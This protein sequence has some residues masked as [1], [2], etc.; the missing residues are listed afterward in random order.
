M[1]TIAHSIDDRVFKLLKSLVKIN[2]DRYKVIYREGLTAKMVR[3][4]PDIEHEELDLN[5]KASTLLA[6]HEVLL[7]IKKLYGVIVSKG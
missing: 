6:L 5:P 4:V 2:S 1:E 7:A 3:N